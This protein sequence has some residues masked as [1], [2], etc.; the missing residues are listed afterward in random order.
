MT[1]A[2]TFPLLTMG[3]RNSANPAEDRHCT[4]TLQAFSHQAG[5]RRTGYAEPTPYR[6]V[7]TLRPSPSKINPAVIRMSATPGKNDIHHWPETIKGL[8][9]LIMTPHSGVGG[10][11]PT[12]KKLNPAVFR[13]AQEIFVV[14]CVMSGREGI[15]Q[16]VAEH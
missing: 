16:Q 12:P 1:Y 6:S 7:R 8:P 4:Q 5:D 9:S 3:I 15:G 13:T 14:D 2:R 11:M 10:C